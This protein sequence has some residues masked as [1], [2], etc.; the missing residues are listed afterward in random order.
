MA[1]EK[2]RLARYTPVNV[3]GLAIEPFT[4]SSMTEALKSS[5]FSFVVDGVEHSNDSE[6]IVL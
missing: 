3:F 6:P 4:R 5:V 1:T 2:G